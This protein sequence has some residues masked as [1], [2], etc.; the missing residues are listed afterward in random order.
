MS[1]LDDIREGIIINKLRQVKRD[2]EA[3]RLK[4]NDSFNF[5][6]SHSKI[7]ACKY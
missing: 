6:M 5:F 7:L 4:A 3:M 2:E 1:L